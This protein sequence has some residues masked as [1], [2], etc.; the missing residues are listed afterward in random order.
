VLYYPMPMYFWF[1]KS[2]QGR[3]LAERVERGMRIMLEDGSY[4]RI[5]AQY[6]DDKIRRLRLASR[7]IIRIDNPLLG[8][9][10]PFADR[11]LWFDPRSYVLRQ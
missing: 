11:R 2:P 8:P 4:D 7:R 6:Q 10:T 1:A 9:D 3:R 5:F